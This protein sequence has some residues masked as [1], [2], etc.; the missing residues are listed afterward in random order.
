MPTWVAGQQGLNDLLL[1][2][3]EFHRER[4][5]NRERGATRMIGRIEMD[6]VVVERVR[7]RRV[8]HRHR[9]WRTLV[10]IMRKGAALSI[11]GEQLLADETC[12]IVV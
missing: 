11:P 1:T 6:I 4:K 7:E 10:T 8:D 9:H 2:S 3:A 5:G 12:T